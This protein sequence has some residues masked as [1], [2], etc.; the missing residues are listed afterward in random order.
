[1]VI[2]FRHRKKAWSADLH[3]SLLAYYC[4]LMEFERGQRW[5]VQ[6]WSQEV[7]V[8]DNGDVDQR[9][10]VTVVAECD[11]LDFVSFHDRVNWDWPEKNRDRVRVEVRTPERHGI[12]GT[13][14][15]VT[16]RWLRKG[17]IKA[18]VHLDRPI[19]R[20]EEFTFVAE[21][22]WPE[23]C[24]PFVRGDGP[25]SFL[26]SFGEITRM[27]EYRVVL[28]KRWAVNFEHFGLTPGR[29]DYVLTASVNQEG[30]MVASLTVRDLP[31]YRKVGLKLDTPSAPA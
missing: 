6:S 25:D 4:D 27:V 31:G 26:V 14:L 21:M 29:D 12:G 11:R 18:F 5:R 2:W 10:R 9:V 1:M 16:H 22:F 19:V 13:R 30:R 23:K 7:R 8:R 15:D 20:G 28:P 17:Q 24:L 3:S